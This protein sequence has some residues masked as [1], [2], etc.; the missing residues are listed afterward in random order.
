M[1][2]A[3][4]PRGCLGLWLRDSLGTLY[5]DADFVTL[6][7]ERGRPAVA[8]WRLALVTVLQFAEAL[9]DR[10]AADAV[11]GRIDWKYALGLALTD[12]GFDFSVLSEFRERVLAGGRAA[13]FLDRLLE[14][15]RE[16]GW[17]GAGGRQRTDSTHVLAA[18]RALGRLQLAEE[19]LRAALDAVAREAPD[20]LAGWA[21]EAWGARYGRRSEAGRL[22]RATAA[23]ERRAEQAGAD[24]VALLGALAAPDAPAGAGLLP[25]VATLRRVWLQQ[26]YAPDEAGRVGWRRVE[27]L[28]PHARAI[29]SPHDV[30][31]RFGRKRELAWVGYKDH[32][33][34][35][36]A[37]ELP[38]LV[39]H[40]ATT[41]ATTDDRAVTPRVQADLAAKG[42]L[43]GEHVVDAGYT[44][45]GLVAQSRRLH[46]I[47]L[48]GPVQQDTSRQ[49]RAG[50][51]FALADFRIDWPQ[52]TVTCPAG[53]PSVRWEPRQTA[54]GTPVIE[55][56]FARAACRACPS[57]AL[58]TTSPAEP[59]QLTLRTQA[60]HD[61]LRAA[62]E[63]QQTPAYRAAYAARAGVEG[64][65]AQAA[66]ALEARR[67][68]YRT[69]A[70]TTLQALA[71]ATAINVLRLFAWTQ[72]PTAY[73]AR[74]S[75]FAALFPPEPAPC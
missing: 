32:L 63:R 65:I 67:A 45:A 72:D 18:V 74:Q 12:P 31:A 42:L 28:P 23:R 22:P 57:R 61:A 71:T 16:R 70:K 53:Q 9:T 38:H 3:A 5:T 10:Q 47:D 55:V 4:F 46:G 29:R 66:G 27:D 21:P 41:A 59:R 56:G 15:C 34:E 37:P 50:A 20:W 49:A 69:L 43:P 54:Y 44:D 35:T 8:P 25:A 52:Q 64:T 14:H 2:R 75:A 36:C 19:T 6:Y 33:T 39:T 60:E 17:L 58:C 7:P 73:L 30:E 24:G 26:F 62:R 1:A 13:V 40:V 51:G 11:R 48:V 68:R